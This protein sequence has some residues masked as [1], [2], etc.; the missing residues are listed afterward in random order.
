MN[1]CVQGIDKRP[2]FER[3]IGASSE[4]S[5]EGEK[6]FDKHSLCSLTRITLN[7]QGIQVNAL[8]R[9]AWQ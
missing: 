8:F 6:F 3:C 1:H 9:P 5:A 4:Q 2:C 7:I